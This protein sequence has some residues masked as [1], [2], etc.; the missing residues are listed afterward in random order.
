VAA[1]GNWG[2]CGS[3]QLLRR[4]WRRRAMTMVV[5]AVEAVMGDDEFITSLHFLT[6]LFAAPLSNDE[7]DSVATGVG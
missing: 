2:G 4:Q 1:D 3:W 7:R 5:V 6:I